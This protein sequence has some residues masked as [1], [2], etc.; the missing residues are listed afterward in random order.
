VKDRPHTKEWKSEWKILETLELSTLISL[1]INKFICYKE[2]LFPT[3]NFV[4]GKTYQLDS[5]RGCGM[6]KVG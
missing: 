2:K 6:E 3:W 1:L 5:A 4:P